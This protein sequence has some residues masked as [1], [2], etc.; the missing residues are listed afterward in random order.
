MDVFET[1][2]EV[3]WAD[4]DP[5]GH[6]RHTVFMDWATQC[7]VAALAAAGLGPR[8]FQELGCGPILFREETDYL[9]EVGAGDRITVSLEVIGASP[10][11]KHWRIRHR[12]VRGDG[13]PCATVVVRGAWFDLGTR[14]VVA[15]PAP[16]AE[17]FAGFP[18]GA[19]FAPIERGMP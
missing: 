5:N 2:C 15:P 6:V 18:R 7:R 17:A 13:A 19:D 14:K 11:W 3:R 16:I 10:D 8:R 1:R 12:L 9:R 4:L